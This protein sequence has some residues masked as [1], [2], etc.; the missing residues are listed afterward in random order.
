VRATR[1]P[2]IPPVPIRCF[3]G[4]CPSASAPG[5]PKSGPIASALIALFRTDHGSIASALFGA[6]RAQSHQHFYRCL[7]QPDAF[8]TAWNNPDPIASASFGANR[9]NRISACSTFVRNPGPIA[10]ALLPLFGCTPGPIASAFSRAL[11]PLFR[12]NRGPIASALLD[13]NRAQS[14]QHLSG[15][16]WIQWYPKSSGPMVSA[17]TYPVS[18][19]GFCLV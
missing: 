7:E 5:G 16:G 3:L 15:P 19:L 1:P 11:S 13:Q 2:G 10:S 14:H 8:T 9:S 17:L 6:N 12:I 4:P 18:T